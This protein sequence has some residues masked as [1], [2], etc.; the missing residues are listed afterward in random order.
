VSSRPADPRAAPA[1]PSAQG[2]AVAPA[3]L[4]GTPSGPAAAPAAPAAAPKAPP[5]IRYGPLAPR[6]PEGAVD[7][8]ALVPGD[9]PLELEIGFGRGA[10]LLGRAAAAPEVRIV[11]L[12]IKA[13]WAYLVEER[14]KARGL[15]NARA[16]GED[17]REALPRLGPD[18]VLGRAYVFFPDPWWK[19]RHA[20][21]RVL[22]PALLDGLARLLRGSAAGAPPGELFVQTDVEERA[23]EV[24][25]LLRA[26]P[27]F[28]LAEAS[29]ARGSVGDNPFGARSNREARAIADGLPIYRVLARRR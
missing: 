16:Y 2:A 12:E 20:K 14:R 24:V 3:A 19:K 17:V 18:G 26:H 28:A 29:D 15:P 4:A 8:R 23:E 13:K 1:G 10:F 9:G 27:A 25:A 5:P 22:D 11:G 21:R 6:L 7:L